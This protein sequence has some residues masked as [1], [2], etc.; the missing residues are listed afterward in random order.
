MFN[1]NLEVLICSY[2]QILN[3]VIVSLKIKYY[4][5]SDIIMLL[6]GQSSLNNVLNR[7]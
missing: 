2:F 5:L 7:T 3:S 1:K 4:D 6:T